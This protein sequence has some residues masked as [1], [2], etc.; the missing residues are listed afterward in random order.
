VRNVCRNPILLQA[1]RRGQEIA[2][3]G[4]IYELHSGRLK[5]LEATVEAERY[6]ESTLDAAVARPSLSSRPA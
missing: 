1:W 4:W 6:A 2:V 3:H 5:D